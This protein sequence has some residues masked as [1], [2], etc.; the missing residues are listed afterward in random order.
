MTHT[1][2]CNRHDVSAD[3]RGD[4]VAAR[5]QYI[6]RPWLLRMLGLS[7]LWCCASHSAYAQESADPDDA[8][9]TPISETIAVA[10]APGDAEI[11][12]R[13]QSIMD[14]TNW[15]EGV[16]VRVESGVVYLSGIAGEEQHKAWAT[17]LVRN[18]SGTVAVINNLRIARA[19]PWDLAPT[20][21]KIREMA[22]GA[23]R[24]LPLIL[25][26]VLLLIA[27]WFIASAVLKAG[28]RVLERRLP[29]QLLRDVIA[30]AIATLVFVLGLYVV[31]R[32]SE[33]TGL[34]V[35]IIGGTGLLGLAIGF[36]FRDI[37]ENFLASILISVQRPFAMGDLIEVDGHTGYVQRVNTRATLIMTRDGNHV[38]IPNAIV[39]KQTIMNFTA[40]PSSR[41]TFV[42]GIGYDD[43]IAEAQTTALEVM[44][45]HPAILD[46][47]EP[48]VLV[49]AL[50]ASTV[51]LRLYF[52][53]DVAT[54]SQQKV[55][56][57]IIRLT[58]SALENAGISMPDEAREVVFPHGVPV[59]V[60]DAEAA[61]HAPEAAG[62]A[63]Q[64]DTDTAH[65]A[66]GD[67]QSEESEVERQARQARLPEGGA[68]L[69]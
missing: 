44:R 51:N 19:S 31:L 35:T 61:A 21:E 62:Q 3:L 37:A 6:A 22:A 48:L 17:E 64:D 7:V 69:L 47:P 56:S 52:W 67:L 29:S 34:A 5:G 38:Q 65:E 8:T 36:A 49:E 20:L 68:N 27:N 39:Y 66:E 58:K 4:A 59:T 32:I 46:D 45:A 54:Y 18:T 43:S 9:D 2:S 53:I 30:R 57:A 33:L 42:V 23:F 26:G 24:A 50:A 60:S 55:R 11:R 41:E 25:I 12:D 28:K 15:F 13:L 10:S 16:D 63:A 40:N 14:A 1:T